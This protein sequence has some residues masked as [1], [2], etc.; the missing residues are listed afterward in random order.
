LDESTS[1]H[2][3]T[4]RVPTTLV[5]AGATLLLALAP[6]AF[7]GDLRHRILPL[8]VLWLAAHAAYL[9]ATWRVLRRAPL[10]A[11]PLA[12]PS[13]PRAPA[14]RTRG[15]AAFAWILGV[16]L[17]ARLV[18]LPTA[19]TLSEDLYRYLWDGRLVASGVNPFP[20]APSDPAL[21]R[22]HDALLGRLNHAD[23]RTIYPPAAQ[24]LFAAAAAIAPEP[25]VWKLLLLALEGILLVSLRSLLR[26]RGLPEERLLLYYWNP[27]VIVE[28]F[29]SGHV[30]LAAA[31]FLLAALALEE[32]RRPL[33]AG[34]AFG[35][36]ILTKYVP[37]LLAPVWVRRGTGR[38]LLVSLGVVLLLFAPFAGAGSSLW[39]GLAMY[40]RRWEFNGSVYPLL[41]AAGLGGD[42]ARVVL[43]AAL[44]ACALVAGWRVR[45]ASAAA[46]AT[47]TALALLSPTL[48]P[49]Y[50]TPIAALLPLHPDAGWLVATG[51]VPLSYVTLPGFAAGGALRLPAWV[52]WVEYGTLAFVWG[53]AWLTRRPQAAVWP[54]A[55]AWTSESPPT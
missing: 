33:W 38:L 17:L 27:L 18:L 10:A 21:A 48:F 4:P 9:G 20:H 50:L 11:H 44:A 3:V 41:R 25:L 30:D 13:P 7:L 47:F 16:G 45:P 46:L 42:A 29:G 40:S 37:A 14:A 1:R 2:R 53:A 8:L 28:S 32:R 51:L 55:E 12:A 5:V 36:S 31:A 23:V 24:L 54:R 15:G 43:A 26:R 19:P 22:F 34:L 35:L 49:W 52:A 39:S 6:I